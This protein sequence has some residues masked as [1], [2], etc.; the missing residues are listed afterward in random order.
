MPYE[1]QYEA[2]DNSGSATNPSTL[3]QVSNSTSGCYSVNFA[4][5]IAGDGTGDYEIA[6]QFGPA[7]FAA[8]VPTTGLGGQT[9]ATVQFYA[10]VPADELL[11]VSCAVLVD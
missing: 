9:F 7:G 8:R 1:G 3:R 6:V 10:Q 11:T 5:L 2:T 4:Y